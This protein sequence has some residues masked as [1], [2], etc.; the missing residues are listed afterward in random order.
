M[1]SESTVFI[2]GAGASWH[3]G[4]PTGPELIEKTCDLARDIKKHVL[5]AQIYGDVFL[6]N[7]LPPSPTYI[8]SG[9]ENWQKFAEDCDRFIQKVETSDPLVIDYFLGQN[10][11]LEKIGK[12]LIAGV[13]TNA[14]SSYQQAYGNPNRAVGDRT[15][16][17]DDNWIKFIT[18][19]LFSKCDVKEDIFQNNVSFITFNYDLSLEEHIYKSLKTQICLTM[20]H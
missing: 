17:K 16:K 9:M 4:Y 13:I 14:H 15:A 6:P 7:F 8:Y 12:F 10:P 2:T 5:K 19:K 11:S 3:Y 18:S 20:T 1:F